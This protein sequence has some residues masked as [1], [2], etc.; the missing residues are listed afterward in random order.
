MVKKLTISEECSSETMSIQRKSLGE[1]ERIFRMKGELLSRRLYIR[2][3]INVTVSIIERERGRS[4][5]KATR[6]D[7]NG[8]VGYSCARVWGLPPRA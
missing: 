2:T 4:N 5:E 8:S 6:V 7:D 1:E 3:A